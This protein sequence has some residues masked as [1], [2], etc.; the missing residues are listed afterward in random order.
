MSDQPED[1]LFAGLEGVGRR[2]PTHVEREKPQ[3]SVAHASCPQCLN[4]KVG[5]VRQGNHLVYKD[6]WVATWSGSSRQC[7]A[8]GQRLCDLPP[9][10]TYA[11]TGTPTPICT[12]T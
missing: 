2:A 1:D 4:D 5:V 7:I 10:D 8:G 11:H 9:R 6:H 12:C 3:R